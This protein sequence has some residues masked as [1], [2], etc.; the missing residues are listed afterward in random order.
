MTPLHVNSFHL[1]VQLGQTTGRAVGCV[2]MVCETMTLLLC[3]I[4]AEETRD[5]KNGHTH[6]STSKR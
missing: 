5:Y 2:Q 3:T 4:F 1:A 6:G